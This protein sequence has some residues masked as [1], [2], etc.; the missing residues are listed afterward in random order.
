M[1]NKLIGKILCLLLF[2]SLLGSLS[3]CDIEQEQTQVK[4]IQTPNQTKNLQLIDADF[5]MTNG[6]DFIE[7]GEN[8]ENLKINEEP[9]SVYANEMRAYDR[10]YYNDFTLFVGLTN[11]REIFSIDMGT[12]AFETARGIR[13]G[14][15]F[16]KVIEKYG[17]NNGET[18]SLTYI[19]KAKFVVF[20]FENGTVN[21]IL[22][23]YF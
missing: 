11:D 21:R 18:E 22:L 16:S 2:I 1:K 10:F 5:I 3:A 4:E 13:V 23:E 6:K 15:S 8:Y 12:S 14:D 7:L 20:Y 17:D 19:Y 9:S